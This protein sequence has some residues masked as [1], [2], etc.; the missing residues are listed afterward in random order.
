MLVLSI[1]YILFYFFFLL[2]FIF[3]SFVLFIPGI[4]SSTCK[5]IKQETTVK[6]ERRRRKDSNDFFERAVT[7]GDSTSELASNIRRCLVSSKRLKRERKKEK[8]T[9]MKK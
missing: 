8:E 2:L 4:N 5:K 3:C 6:I 1:F 7:K 9:S